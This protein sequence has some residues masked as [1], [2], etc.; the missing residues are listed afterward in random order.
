MLENGH[1]TRHSSQE[2]PAAKFHGNPGNHP[3][4]RIAQ[5]RQ[6]RDWMGITRI[7]GLGSEFHWHGWKRPRGCCG[8]PGIF[9]D[10]SKLQFMG[11]PPI[12]EILIPGGSQEC[13][14]P[15]ETQEPWEH[16]PFP[17]PPHQLIQ[18]EFQPGIREPLE[19]FMG[20]R[21]P[22]NLSRIKS[23]LGTP[24]SKPRKLQPDS[25]LIPAFPKFQSEFHLCCNFL[26]KS[27]QELKLPTFQDHRGWKRHPGLN[28]SCA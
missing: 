6:G 25:K 22:S 7:L 20:C 3:A 4:L 21:H 9:W 1:G 27:P 10:F 28:P 11:I 15:E 19:K 23:F 14:I 2:I 16:A 18:L 5:Q 17:P 12:Q 26:G 24:N 8:F 13:K